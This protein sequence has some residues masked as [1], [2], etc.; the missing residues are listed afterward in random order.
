MCCSRVGQGFAP[1]HRYVDNCY[2]RSVQSLNPPYTNRVMLDREP[3]LKAIID[4][5]EDD[6]PRLVYADFLEETGDEARAEFIR[7]QCELARLHVDDPMRAALAIREAE[8]LGN[9]EAWIIPGMVA[10]TQKFRRGFVESMETTAAA[11]VQFAE[12]IFAATPLQHLRA[13]NPDNP[14]EQFVRIEHLARLSS[15]DV[16]N[17]RSATVHR[18]LSEAPLA[19]LRRLAARNCRIWPEGLANLAQL[20]AVARLQALDLAGNLLSDAG[21]ETLASHRNFAGL[22]SL[23]LRSDEQAE[24]Y[25]IHELGARTLA[26]SRTLGKL[27]VLDLGGNYLGDRGFLAIADAANFSE[28]RE[29]NLADNDIRIWPGSGYETLL[30]APSWANLQR[31]NLSRNHID[32][33]AVPGLVHWIR[34]KKGRILVLERIV[35]S[36]ETRQL[37]LSIPEAASMILDRDFDEE[38]N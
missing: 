32:L 22:I 18:I 3:F 21:V 35:H 30:R 5:P 37:L 9:R 15:L 8:L 17:G 10:T 31:L 19:N 16:S 25:C 28:I 29:L 23:I 34:R 6:L 33:E 11:F 38:S 36:A 26:E 13:V 24:E 4:R 14:V 12:V 2:G 20:P 1:T 7:V 27:E